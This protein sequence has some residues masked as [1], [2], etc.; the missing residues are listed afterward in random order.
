MGNLEHA[1]EIVGPFQVDGAIEDFVAGADVLLWLL[2]TI[3]TPPHVETLRFSRQRHL[4]TRRGL[5]LDGIVE[6]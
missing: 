2:V 1:P 3:Q 5:L 6:V 4:K